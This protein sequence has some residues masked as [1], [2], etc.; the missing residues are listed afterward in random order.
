MFL[1]TEHLPLRHGYIRNAFLLSR[2]AKQSSSIFSLPLF[3]SFLP[4]FSFKIKEFIAS[5]KRSFLKSSKLFFAQTPQVTVI[6]S[7]AKAFAEAKIFC[8]ASK[9]LAVLLLPVFPE[10]R[11]R[12]AHH[13]KNRM[14]SR[15]RSEVFARTER[16][17]RFAHELKIE[18]LFRRFGSRSS[19]KSGT[20]QEPCFLAQEKRTRNHLCVKNCV[21]SSTK[22]KE[23]QYSKP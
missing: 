1:S 12:P 9:Y 10:G 14:C 6:F 3:L 19:E 15:L 22:E 4:S 2:P 11:D 13:Q 5:E 7:N 16:S 8:P 21:K 17:A 20:K 18:I 23:E